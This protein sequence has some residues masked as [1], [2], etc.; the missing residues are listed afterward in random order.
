MSQGSIGKIYLPTRLYTSIILRINQYCILTN[1]SKSFTFSDFAMR[2]YSST[3]INYTYRQYISTSEARFKSG[4]RSNVGKVPKEEWAHSIEL[5]NRPNLFRT[6]K[7]HYISSCSCPNLL[8]PYQHESDNLLVNRASA[9]VY[10]IRFRC[11]RHRT[12][13]KSVG[14]GLEILDFFWFYLWSWFRCVVN[15]MPI[16]IVKV[17]GVL[18]MQSEREWM[19]FEQL[20]RIQYIYS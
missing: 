15:S 9:Y 16:C 18:F 11:I 2:N 3:T 1:C 8:L 10:W 14:S 5:S 4:C 7:G 6:Q 20:V 12:S 19:I 17:Y 13:E